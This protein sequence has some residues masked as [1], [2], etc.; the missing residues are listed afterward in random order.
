M[1]GELLGCADVVV[2]HGDSHEDLGPICS[3]DER[4]P[5]AAIPQSLLVLEVVEVEVDEVDEVGELE[6]GV[7]GFLSAGNFGDLSVFLF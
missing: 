4:Y 6:G 5:K 3:H 2:F 7:L 1:V